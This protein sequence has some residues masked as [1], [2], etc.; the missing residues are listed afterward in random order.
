MNY[1]EK[2][3]KIQKGESFHRLH[4]DTRICIINMPSED[5]QID[6]FLDETTLRA[7]NFNNIVQVVKV[8]FLFFIE[9]IPRYTS[10]DTYYEIMEEALCRYDTWKKS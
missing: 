8:G 6:L 7:I 9:Y 5:M 4:P 10:R 2:R 1:R 3:Y